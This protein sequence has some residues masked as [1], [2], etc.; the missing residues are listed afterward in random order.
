MPLVMKPKTVPAGPSKKAK[1][2]ELAVLP[3]SAK[4]RPSAGSTFSAKSTSVN[5]PYRRLTV[6][7]DG[8]RET[9][10]KLPRIALVGPEDKIHVDP[11]VSS[12]VSAIS[13]EDPTD[14]VGVT[15]HSEHREPLQ[16]GALRY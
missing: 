5:G 8:G 13:K 14:L 6:S 16:L 7:G 15:P 9:R 12:R 10:L 1:S 11:V 4:R 2:A 3:N